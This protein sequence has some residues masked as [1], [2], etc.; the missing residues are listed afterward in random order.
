MSLPTVDSIG[1]RILMLDTDLADLYGVQTFRLNEGVKRNGKR[2]P[3]DFM[4]QLTSAESARLT[5]QIAMSKPRGRGGR[6]TAPFVFTEHGALMLANVLKSGRAA[7]ISILVVRAFVRLREVL[8]GHKEL[9]AKL[10]ELESRVAGHDK[11]IAELLRAIRALLRQPEPVSR[12]IG[13]TADLETKDVR[14][15]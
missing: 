2:F 8:A 3:P 14:P 15:G 5:S 13:F 12:P 9:A 6:R 4:F 10:D 11:A 7:E 1:D